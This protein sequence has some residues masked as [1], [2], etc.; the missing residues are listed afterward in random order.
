M[1]TWTPPLLVLLMLAS[2]AWKPRATL[3]LLGYVGLSALLLAGT[4]AAAGW[5]AWKTIL[6]LTEQ[7]R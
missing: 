2:V 7:S 5:L 4:T 3:R 1:R 6:Y